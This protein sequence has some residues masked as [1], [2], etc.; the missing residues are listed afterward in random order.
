MLTDDLISSLFWRMLISNS[1][2]DSLSV[3]VSSLSLRSLSSTSKAATCLVKASMPAS[4]LPV[5]ALPVEVEG[6]EATEQTEE[7]ELVSL[8]L[9]AET[10]AVHVDSNDFSRLLEIKEMK[11]Y[12]N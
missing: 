2:S 4:L 7:S 12:T 1:R 6:V 3:A 8:Q 10:A 9:F 11:I 5:P